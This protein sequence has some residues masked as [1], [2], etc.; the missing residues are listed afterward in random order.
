METL[1]LD[2][3]V[4]GAQ[5]AG[6]IILCPACG[7]AMLE[8]DRLREGNHIFILFECSQKDCGGQW[9]QKK[10]QFS[11]GRELSLSAI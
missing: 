9:L 2:R 5:W 7:A 4:T 11:M 6:S 1:K 10:S 3:A 8:A